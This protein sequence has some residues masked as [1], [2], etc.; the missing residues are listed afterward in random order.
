M[1][2]RHKA[3]KPKVVF[4]RQEKEFTFKVGETMAFAVDVIGEP[5]CEN[6]V[7]TLGNTD[8]MQVEGNGIIVDNSKPYISK[9]QKENLTRKDEAMLTV[10]ASNANGKV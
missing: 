5:P 1:V 2:A 7:W 9:L 10:T 8:L 4:K 3:L 6:I